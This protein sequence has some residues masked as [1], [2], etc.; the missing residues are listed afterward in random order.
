MSAA[1]TTR[2]RRSRQSRLFDPARRV[3][4]ET[5][6]PPTPSPG[7]G[8]GGTGNAEGLTLGESLARVWEGLSVTGSATCP[9]CDAEMRRGPG[10]AG[11]RCGSCGTA[12][13]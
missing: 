13:R 9:L 7:D 3:S 4:T 5:R 6:T 10:R 11:G 12:V 2:A 1:T 8:I